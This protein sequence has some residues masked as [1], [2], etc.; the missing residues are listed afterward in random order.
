MRDAPRKI[1]CTLSEF[2]VRQFL[3]AAYTPREIALVEFL[4]GTGCRVSE[5]T[6]LR[7]EEIDFAA[8][9]ARVSGK[10]PHGRVVLITERAASALQAHIASEKM[11]MYSSQT[12]PFKNSVS[13]NAMDIS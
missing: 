1:P 5:V 7:M 11:A 6:S 10:D 12:C 3:A 8:R 4:Y 13:R 9:T 2:E